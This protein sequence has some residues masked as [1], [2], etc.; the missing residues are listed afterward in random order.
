MKDCSEKKNKDK[1]REYFLELNH[2]KINY[3]QN[4]I[5]LNLYVSN[6]YIMIYLHLVI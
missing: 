6:T 4:Q 2:E 3:N 5:I 1:I